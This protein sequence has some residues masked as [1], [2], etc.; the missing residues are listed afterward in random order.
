MLCA[1]VTSYPHTCSHTGEP[2][3][4]DNF[5]KVIAKRMVSPHLTHVCIISALL[6]TSPHVLQSVRLV[7]P[8]SVCETHY[9]LPFS[10]T[11]MSVDGSVVLY[12]Q[13]NLQ[14]RTSKVV[15]L[16]I[17]LVHLGHDMDLTPSRAQNYNL[18]CAPII[19]WEHNNLLAPFDSR[20]SN[21]ASGT[22]RAS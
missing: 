20:L 6:V 7:A 5:Y 10:E 13:M 12:N 8:H 4:C 2:S 1:L 15:K 3:T 9:S 21:M 17:N 19:V 18:V 11:D 14:V 16:S 22:L